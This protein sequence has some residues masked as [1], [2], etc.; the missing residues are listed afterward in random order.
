MELLQIWG[1]NLFY[2]DSI[3]FNQNSIASVATALSLTL[4]V[5]GP[6]K[7]SSTI[8][9]NTLSLKTEKRLKVWQ[10]KQ[11][12]V[13]RDLSWAI[14]EKVPANGFRG[15]FESCLKFQKLVETIN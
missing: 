1:C 7:W 15:N 6:L 3:V 5:K 13:T 12:Q 2:N 8:Y 14:Q 9:L 4:S 11:K 10:S